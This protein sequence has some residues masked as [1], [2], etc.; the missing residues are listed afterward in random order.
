MDALKSFTPEAFNAIIV[1]AL[2]LSLAIG[3]WRF[4]KD[5]QR[6]PRPE[7]DDQL[8]LEDMRR[9]YSQ[10]DTPQDTSRS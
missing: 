10:H 2:G 3:G 9:F 1:F 5:M 7:N 4:Y 8:Y 6:E